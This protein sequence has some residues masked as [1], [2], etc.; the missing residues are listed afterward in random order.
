LALLVGIVDDIGPNERNYKKGDY[1]DKFPFY[2]DSPLDHFPHIL[3]ICLAHYFPLDCW[4]FPPYIG[5]WDV[6]VRLYFLGF[7]FHFVFFGLCPD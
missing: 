5:F 2:D 3:P 1:L 7:P 6:I 4:P